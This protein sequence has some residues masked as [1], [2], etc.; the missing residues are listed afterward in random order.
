MTPQ[1]SLENETK[2]AKTS[3]WLKEIVQVV[4]PI[5]IL[6]A[7]GLACYA[8]VASRKNTRIALPKSL[9]VYVTYFT[10][11]TR[12]DGK[13][14]VQPDIYG[15]DGKLGAFGGRMISCEG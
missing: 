7:G 11:A 14:A 4:L 12:A 13:V 2:M 3:F 15:R 5:L 1:D 6:A 9:P 8:I 10:A